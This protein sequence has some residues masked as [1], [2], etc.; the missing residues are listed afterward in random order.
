MNLIKNL[1]LVFLSPILFIAVAESALFLMYQ[2]THSK[3]FESFNE[4]ISNELKIDFS[5]LN[6]D[7]INIGV[8]GGSS[9]WG[10]ASPASFSDL[11]QKAYPNEFVIHN[12]AIGGDPFV[13]FQSEYLK[14][15]MPYYDVII[16]YAG[17]NEIWSK[18]YL[19]F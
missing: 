15:V 10:Y 5:E 6:R 8:F 7:N 11:I 18:L 12:Y 3:Y 9:A 16:I 14:L 1:M 2:T 4:T 17:H 19:K 13:G